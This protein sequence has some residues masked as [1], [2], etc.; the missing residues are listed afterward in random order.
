MTRSGYVDDYDF[1]HWSH[2]R[3]R[4]Q[5]A[6]SIRGSR[7]QAFLSELLRAL[8]E[9]PEKRLIAHELEKDGEVCAIGALARRR[10][11]DVSGLDPEDYGQ[12]AKTFNVASPL[13]RE[14]VYIND[15]HTLNRNET[16]EARFIRVRAWVVKQIKE[17]SL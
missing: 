17:P 12:V 4:G 9:M 14:M 6:S 11:L 7:G 15:E 13:A 5:V 2:I 1:D 8:D 3:W 10:N 16:P